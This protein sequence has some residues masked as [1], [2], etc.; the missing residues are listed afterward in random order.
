M[1]SSLVVVYEIIVVG[2]VV[3][4]MDL[5]FINKLVLIIFVMEIMEMWC[6]FNFLCDFVLFFIVFIFLK[7]L[8]DY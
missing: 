2:F 5:F 8:K 7:L 4:I 1:I 6:C 3:L